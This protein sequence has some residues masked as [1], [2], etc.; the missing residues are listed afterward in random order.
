MPSTA[1]LTSR[2]PVAPPKPAALLARNAAS[3]TAASLAEIARS[4]RSVWTGAAARRATPLDLATRGA[5]WWTSMTDRRVPTWNLPHRTVLSTPFA[6]RAR[7]LPR[8]RRHRRRP[9]AGAAARRPG[10]P[11]TSSTSHRAR[12]SS[13]VLLE[14]GLTQPVRDG[15]AGG[16]GGD[17]R[18]HHHRLPRRHR[19]GDRARRRPRQPR[20]RL[21]G[22][23][24]GDDLR[25]A[26]PGAGAHAHPGRGADR[27][28]RRRVAHRGVHARDDPRPGDGAL[29]H[30]RRA[31]RR[32]HVGPGGPLEL[33]PDAAPDRAGAPV[34]PAR[35]R[36]RPR[37]R[38]AL[39][40]LRGLVQAHPGHS[41]RLLP[42]AGRAPVPQERA[43]R[44]AAGDRRAPRRPREH[45]L[46]A[47]PPR[48]GPRPHH[49]ARPAV[50]GRRCR[51]HAA[52]RRS[53]SGRR[54]VDTSASSPAG[55]RSPRTGRC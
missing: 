8:R 23:L 4:S 51:G 15:V 49:A 32:Q 13:T 11:R 2:A 6:A 39:P 25:H 27:L 17:P 44:R 40:G 38:R 12:A 9:H 35:E 41:R 10:T 34:R 20:R 55:R 30:P 31:Q 33:H 46:S 7:L 14:A 1:D 53:C 16:H 50:R 42:V 47:V 21:S 28:P 45:H 48:R 19:P 54:P 3:N 24:A 43:H 29:P 5:Q 36:R 37:A 18:G 26:A 52:R 22:R